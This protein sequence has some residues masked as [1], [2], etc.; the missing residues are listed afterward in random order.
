MDCTARLDRPRIRFGHH[1]VVAVESM[2]LTL[3][4]M[5]ICRLL[6][7]RHNVFFGVVPKPEDKRQG[8]PRYECSS[9]HAI[10]HAWS[11]FTPIDSDGC[12]RPS[13]DD[14]FLEHQVRICQMTAYR[15][16][17]KAAQSALE[18]RGSV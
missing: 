7:L 14:W 9:W 1:G 2:G 16:L 18:M 17:W 11:V 15:K 10:A 12:S 3:S 13:H 4:S 8:P 5:R 6:E